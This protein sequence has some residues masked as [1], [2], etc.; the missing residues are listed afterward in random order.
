MPRPPAAPDSVRPD[1][2]ELNQR[3]RAF[4]AGRVVWSREALGELGRLQAAYLAADR[5]ERVGQA[6]VA[7]VA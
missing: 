2:A 5:D 3:I 6:G 1:A 4:T 7:E